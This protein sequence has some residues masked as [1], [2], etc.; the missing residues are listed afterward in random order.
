MR[1]LSLF[2]AILLVSGLSFAQQRYL[3]SP[4]Q[5][6]IPITKYDNASDL[7]AKRQSQTLSKKTAGE[8]GTTFLF[9]YDRVRYPS[10]S[11]FGAYHK[12]VMAQWY[13]A[14]A[15]GEI[16]TVFWWD[17]AGE[18]GAK[19]SLILLRILESNLGPNY[20]P[21][22]PP[23]KPPCQSWGYWYSTNDK[24][25][26]VAAF[27]EDATDTTWISTIAPP[28]LGGPPTRPPWGD[29]IWGFGGYGKIHRQGLNYV[30]PRAETNIPL[31]VTVGQR[32]VISFKVNSGPDH[33]VNDIATRWAA[34]GSTGPVS[35][36]DED[37]PARNWKFYEHDSGPWPSCA[38]VNIND[39][40]KGWVARGPL[41]TGA[42]QDWTAAYNFWYTMIVTTNVAPLIEPKEDGDVYTTFSTGPQT[43]TYDIWDCDPPNPSQAEVARAFIRYRVANTEAYTPFTP[44]WGPEIDV[45]MTEVITDVYSGTI[46]GLPAGKS[47]SYTVY[48][49]DTK[50]LSN[51][52]VPQSYKVVSLKNPY[53]WVDT[54]ANPVHKN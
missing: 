4:N 25:Q 42:T 26:G 34:W 38:G 30:A 32:F 19:D 7:I 39:V 20:G 18:N 54:V 3:V 35:T 43:I 12:D 13:I 23:H 24:D 8:C 47:V 6:V 48:A 17:I 33:I 53:Y 27:I 28:P 51:R 40:K 14:K 50:G 16:D 5:E 10:T 41:G 29:E 21:G 1:I 36:T 46:P 45:E 52:G 11:R 15:S 44:V 2:L 31:E 9:G 37:W 49:F 22:V